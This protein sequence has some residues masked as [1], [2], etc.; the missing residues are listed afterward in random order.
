MKT[1]TILLSIIGFLALGVYFSHL[2]VTGISGKELTTMPMWCL[3]GMILSLALA[4]ATIIIYFWGDPEKPEEKDN[5]QRYIDW[6]N[7]H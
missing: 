5:Y 4:S 6:C 2:F 1:L 7:K 3:A